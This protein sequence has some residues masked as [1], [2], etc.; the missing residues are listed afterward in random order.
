MFQ[1][2]LQAGG[3]GGS[4]FAFETFNVLSNTK[5]YTISNKKGCKAFMFSFMAWP[6]MSLE[7]GYGKVQ[8]ITGGNILENY[9]VLGTSKYYVGDLTTIEITSDNCTITFEN[10]S[11]GVMGIIIE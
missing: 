5:S 3:S 7:S 2:M 10:N 4:G 11:A 9:R 6:D 8:S 1:K